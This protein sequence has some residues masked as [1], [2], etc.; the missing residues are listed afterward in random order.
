MSPGF[1]RRYNM[2]NPKNAG[3]SQTENHG[4][5]PRD[6]SFNALTKYM[7]GLGIAFVLAFL[8]CIGIYKLFVR[9]EA[10]PLLSV[11]PAPMA[12]QL[13]P[14]PRLQA[15]PEK[16]WE[17]FKLSQD[18]A[19]TSYGSVHDSFAEIPVSRAMQIMLKK[20]YPVRPAEGRK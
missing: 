20:G 15:H 17:S 2:A 5:E 13:P 18:K 16:E 7:W 12:K 14:E 19:Y 9:T 8:I 3:H 4:Y 11:L 10:A 1:R 6:I